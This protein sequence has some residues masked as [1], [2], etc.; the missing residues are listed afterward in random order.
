M[1][2]AGTLGIML[3]AAV[4]ATASVPASFAQGEGA[5]TSVYGGGSRAPFMSA[6]I[7]PHRAGSDLACPGL[8]WHINREPAANGGLTLSGP[9]WMDSGKGVSFAQGSSDASGRFSLT[10]TPVSGQ[11]PS[12][13]LSGVRHPNGTVDLTATGTPCFSGTYHLKP[14]QTTAQP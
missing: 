10:V 11:G 7:A 14:G 13:T 3:G 6:G 9:I 5:G 1:K 4:F 8:T 12:G 2:L